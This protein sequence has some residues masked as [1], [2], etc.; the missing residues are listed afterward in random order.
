MAEVSKRF[1]KRGKRRRHRQLRA[2]F[3]FWIIYHFGRIISIEQYGRVGDVR[4]V[5]GLTLTTYIPSHS[6]QFESLHAYGWFGHSLHDLHMYPE[7]EWM[8]LSRW[9][10]FL[11]LLSSDSRP[12]LVGLFGVFFKS[13][14]T[15]YVD[16]AG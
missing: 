1:S 8:F 15:T 7:A 2:L 5:G 13:F 12:T 3:I 6:C 9:V 14:L 4:R 10:I 11:L 16:R